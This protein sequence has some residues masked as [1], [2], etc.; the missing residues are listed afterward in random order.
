MPEVLTHHGALP[1]PSCVAWKTCSR[2]SHSKDGRIPWAISSSSLLLCSGSSELLMSICISFA[3]ATI[4]L[5]SHLICISHHPSAHLHLICINQRQGI[6]NALHLPQ[7]RPTAVSV[8]FPA[9]VNTGTTPVP[10]RIHTVTTA[11]GNLPEQTTTVHQT[12][13]GDSEERT[14]KGRPHSLSLLLLEDNA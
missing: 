5:S 6:Q 13:M 12:Q 9:S 4:L 1:T 11:P 10:S 8:L 2:E 14:P 7:A 3:Y